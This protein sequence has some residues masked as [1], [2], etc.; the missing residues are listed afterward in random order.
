MKRKGPDSYKKKYKNRTLI[1]R[2][3]SANGTGYE[4]SQ[5]TSALAICRVTQGYGVNRKREKGTCA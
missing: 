1:P 2:E 4:N 3:N 5:P